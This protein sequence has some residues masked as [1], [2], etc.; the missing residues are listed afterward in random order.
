MSLSVDD[1]AI[2]GAGPIG[3]FGAY[4][5][6][7]RGLKA[8]LIEALPEAGGQL[9]AMYPEKDIFDVGGLPRIRARELV[10]N[11]MRQGLGR[12]GCELSLGEK[13]ETLQQTEEGWL[14]GTSLGERQA[15][16]VV[17]TTGIGAFRP[18][19]LGLPG[20][21]RFQGKGIQYFVKQLEELYGKRIV[22][23][24]GGDSAVDWA[25]TFKDKAEVTIVH[26]REHF[27]A[28]ELSVAEMLASPVQVYRPWQVVALHGDERLEAVTIRKVQG[29]E[30]LDIPCDV[31][32]VCFGFAT[33][34]GPIKQWGLEL[35][36][37]K[38]KVDSE[39]RTN[40]PGVFAAGDCITYPGR[41][42]LIALGF[43]EVAIAVSSAASYLRPGQRQGYVHSSTRGY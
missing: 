13:V 36:G 41:L 11:L 40:L 9:M 31:L 22:I 14:L 10:E 21:E 2:I 1:L 16:A 24:G 15:R 7:L 23:A 18:K 34:L 20:E 25:N 5:A 29:E 6:E 30:T 3:L 4:H 43:G 19:P 35:E 17:I 28:H 8:R 12:G 38:I 42:N 39:M 27:A 33:D 32:L 26:R 37:G